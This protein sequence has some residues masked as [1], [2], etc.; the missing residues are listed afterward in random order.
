MIFI[1]RAHF[2][3]VIALCAAMIIAAMWI[4]VAQETAV[5]LIG[6]VGWRQSVIVFC[7][8]LGFGGLAAELTALAAATAPGETPAVSS[9]VVLIF[10]LPFYGVMILLGV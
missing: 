7:L 9:I 10:A 1:L 5:T 6:V 2:P 4:W 3:G 8:G